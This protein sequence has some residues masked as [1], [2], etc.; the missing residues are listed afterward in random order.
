MPLFDGLSLLTDPS[1][2]ATGYPTARLQ[3]GLLLA[4]RGHS[5]AEEGVGFGVPILKRGV[6]T[7]F[8]GSVELAAQRI[9]SGAV[10]EVTA[11]YHMNLI[12]RLAKPGGGRVRSDALHTTKNALAALHRRSRVLRGPLTAASATLRRAFGWVTTYEE[13]S[14]WATLTVTHTIRAEL[15]TIDITVDMTGLPPDGFTEIVLMNEQGAHHF[16]RYRD[17]GGA[18]LRGAAI[19]T[20]DQVGAETASFVS[21]AHA[22][23]FSLG[24][25]DGARLN[26]GREL[27]GA[28]LAWSGFGYSVPPTCGRFAYSL[29]I[30][31][32]S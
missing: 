4:D 3:K 11:A 6:V 17:S 2:R 7:V 5:L 16:D 31:R 25:V 19:G 23:A 1:R 29:S 28:R 21:D 32:T 20:W 10:W 12:E 15:G 9:C 30:E 13:I 14:S 22:V 18:D 27:I 24:Q 26:R 8:P